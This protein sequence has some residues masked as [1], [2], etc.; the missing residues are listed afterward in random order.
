MRTLISVLSLSL[1]AV[2]GA[3]AAQG[4]PAP[5]TLRVVTPFA[6]GHLLADTAEKFKEELAR[7]APHLQV[8]VQTGVLNEQT[9]DPAFQKCAAGERVGE[10]LLTGGQPIQDYA[11]KYF[12]FNGPYVIRDFA[13]LLAVWRGEIGSQMAQQLEAVGNQVV[14]EPVYRGYRQF[15]ANK[16][17]SVPADF[18]GLKLRLP[19]TPDW[20]AVWN[21]LGTQAVQVP[22]PGIY[23][24]L[25]S[26][27]AAASEGDLT[28]I[29]SLKLN[30]VQSHLVLTNHLVGFG[31][32][33]ANACFYR[34]ELSAEDQAKVRSAMRQATR[35]GTQ[36]I[37]AREAEIIA[38]LQA[39]GMTVVKPDGEAIRKA[40]EPAID[41]LFRRTWTVT[42]WAEILAK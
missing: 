6:K 33:A 30:E 9:I 22:L 24:A 8:S 38:Q 5:M 14:F 15:T 41:A 42:S 23:D 35:W 3:A 1:L 13:H 2:C 16:A 40:A 11:P 32:A 20:I 19:P 10:I 36:S 26:G 4:E 39:G 12:F 37:V 27:A 25:Q 34:H 18:N 21:S 31:V 28:Q 29:Q 17:I 7:T